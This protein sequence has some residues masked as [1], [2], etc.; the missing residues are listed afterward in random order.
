M[1]GPFFEIGPDASDYKNSTGKVHFHF[2]EVNLDYG[3]FINFG[4]SLNMNLFGGVGYAKINQY[5]FTTFAGSSGDPYRTITVPSKF[6]R[7]F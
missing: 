6:C 7:V 2:D 1:I 5:R 4:N 3:T